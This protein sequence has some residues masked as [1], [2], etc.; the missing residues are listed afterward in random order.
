MD[1]GKRVSWLTVL[2][3][4]L[5]WH[6]AHPIA[7]AADQAAADKKERPQE[8]APANGDAD[9]ANAEKPKGPNVFV[10]ADRAMLQ[11]LDRGSAAASGR[12]LCR[13]GPLPRGDP[14]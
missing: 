1:S 3:V 6:G 2:A 13:G 9:K 14:R 4:V 8:A 11:L 7:E 12:S 5:L 10:P